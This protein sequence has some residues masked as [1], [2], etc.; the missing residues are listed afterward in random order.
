M[1]AGKVPGYVADRTENM[2]RLDIKGSWESLDFI[3]LDLYF[4]CSICYLCLCLIVSMSPRPSNHLSS[5]L[6]PDTVDTIL[7]AE[8][9]DHQ[10]EHHKYI[11]RTTNNILGNALEKH[12]K[13]LDIFLALP[14]LVAGMMTPP[15]VPSQRST[16]DQIYLRLTK[17]WSI[18]LK[19]FPQKNCP[20]KEFLNQ[21]HYRSLLWFSNRPYH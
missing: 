12:N 19:H 18:S 21:H 9:G 13:Y 14:I 6:T 1:N 3:H 17:E 2:S 16:F 15:A 11:G 8:N 7:Q 4:L 5:A 10:D 20:K